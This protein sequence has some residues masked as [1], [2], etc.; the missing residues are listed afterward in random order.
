MKVSPRIYLHAGFQTGLIVPCGTQWDSLGAHM[1]WILKDLHRPRHGVGLNRAQ[2]C[3]SGKIDHTHLELAPRECGQGST[4]VVCESWR[5]TCISDIP[6][7]V[8]WPLPP[9]C[10]GALNMV[11]VGPTIPKMAVNGPKC[12][13][14]W[15]GQIGHIFDSDRG[16]P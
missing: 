10:K 2:K 1:Y 5:P 14:S 11:Q 13:Y 7:T 15:W 16:M 8:H 3:Q 9:A 12:A 6:Y 4:H